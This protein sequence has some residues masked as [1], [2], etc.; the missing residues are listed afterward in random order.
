MLL[1]SWLAARRRT[2]AI[3]DSLKAA[4]SRARNNLAVLAS[5]SLLF[6]KNQRD[7]GNQEPEDE[8]PLIKLE[9]PTKVPGRPPDGYTLR[10]VAGLEGERQ[11]VVKLSGFF[12]HFFLAEC[13]SIALLNSCQRLVAASK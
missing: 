4:R 13:S 1:S 3:P 10:P 8:H 9:K 5:H 11:V 6:G 7:A 2:G 12:H